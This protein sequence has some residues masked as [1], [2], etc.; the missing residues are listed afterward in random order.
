MPTDAITT[1]DSTVPLAAI[2]Q[3]R[4][5][6]GRVDF[7]LFADRLQFDEHRVFSR[8]R[9]FLY[10]GGVKE[11]PDV[12]GGHPWLG[13]A[14]TLFLGLITWHIVLAAVDE[15]R[16]MGLGA[17]WLLVVPVF[18]TGAACYYFLSTV[19]RRRH[20]MAYR[21]YAVTS[22]QSRS[23]P[24][25]YLDARRWNHDEV[26]KFLE[27]LRQVHLD[28]QQRTKA[29]Q[30]AVSGLSEAEMLSKFASLHKEAI[31]TDD[32]FVLVKSKIVGADGQRIG[33]RAKSQPGM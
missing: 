20:V 12:L 3:R 9:R 24:W 8:E 1:A 25:L 13:L 15:Y 33:F 22:T 17:L 30:A 14:A 23:V 18:A 32:E 19:G 11:Q 6:V 4:W 2:R 10:F 27:R 28:W 29:L 31:L 5:L 16:R 26:D 21:A 7:T